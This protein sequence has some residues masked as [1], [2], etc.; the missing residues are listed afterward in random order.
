MTLS[1]LTGSMNARGLAFA[2][3]MEPVKN[4]KETHKRKRK[5]EESMDN[6]NK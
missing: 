5:K 6:E 2:E 1:L 4:A 3:S